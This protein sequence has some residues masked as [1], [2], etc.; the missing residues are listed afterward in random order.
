MLDSATRA[1]RDALRQE[2]GD[3]EMAGRMRWLEVVA[4]VR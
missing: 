2:F 4:T 3:G 1:A